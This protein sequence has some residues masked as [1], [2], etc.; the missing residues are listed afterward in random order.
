MRKLDAELLLEE[1]LDGVFLDRFF[2]LGVLLLDV[3]TVV[4]A[5]LDVAFAS[6]AVPGVLLEVPGEPTDV[7]PS[8][9]ACK[10]A[11]AVVLSALS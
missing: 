9:F 6:L 8:S 1:D 3:A 7:F 10:T 11:P 4:D 2:F 5:A